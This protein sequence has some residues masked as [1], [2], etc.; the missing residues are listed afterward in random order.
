MDLEKQILNFMKKKNYFPLTKEELAVALDINF[1]NLKHFF[2]ILDSLIKSKKISCNDYKYSIYEKKKLLKG[3]IIFTPK[4][5]AFFVSDDEIDDIFIPKNELNNA[6]HCDDVEI[7]ITKDKE[8][9]RKAEGR[10][11]KVLN[12]NNN[13][14]IGTFTE[15]KNF[16]FVVP[17]DLK[18]NYDIFIK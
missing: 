6:N 4:G 15:N 13:I 16:G 7:E 8:I 3:K 5:N 1:A 11:V 10:V 18:Y 17:D 12:R 14:I 2:N 9:N